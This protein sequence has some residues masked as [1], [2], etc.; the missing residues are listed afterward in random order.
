MVIQMIGIRLLSW[1]VQQMTPKNQVVLR[2][3][4]NESSDLTFSGFS[5]GILDAEADSMNQGLSGVE[6]NVEDDDLSE[7]ESDSEDENISEFDNEESQG[8][9]RKKGGSL[10]VLKSPMSTLQ[11]NGV[12][13]RMRSGFIINVWESKLF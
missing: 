13:M 5:P 7:N 9:S 3:S 10:A 2:C 6:D 8:S 1:M 4:Q 12:R 11:C